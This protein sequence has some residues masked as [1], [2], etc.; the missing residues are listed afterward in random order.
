DALIKMMLRLY[1][2][3]MFSS[4]VKV[5]ETVLARALKVLR[6]DV[7]D[8]L[9]HLNDLKV[10]LYSPMRDKPQV[11]YILPRQDA[12]N[13]P[14]DRRRLEARRSLVLDKMKSMI[15]FVETDFRCRM[16]MI[17]EYFGEETDATCGICDVCI[18]KRKR[19]TSSRSASFGMKCWR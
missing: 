10:L 11:T 13:L 5:D 9:Q 18:E 8:M 7:V 19:T 6:Q 1:G 14:V 16:Q 3:E 15:S 12:E 2:G 17:Q 4:F